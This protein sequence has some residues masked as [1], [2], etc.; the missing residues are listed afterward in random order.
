MI[1]LDADV[2]PEPLMPVPEPAVL[3]WLDAQAPETLY[4]TSIN[5]AETQA[6]IEVLLT[7]R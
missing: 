3:K 2:L 1:V 6:G 5:L 7:A 4:L